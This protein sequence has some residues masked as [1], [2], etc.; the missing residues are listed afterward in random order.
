MESFEVNKL[1]G[2]LLATVFVVMS[3]AIVSDGIYSS[4]HP[5]KEGY[6]IVADEEAA[7][8]GQAGG[9]EAKP[10][11]IAPLIAAADPKAGEAVFKKCTACH[12]DTKGGPNKVGPNL[13]GVID[14]PI[15]SHAG[16]SYSAAMKE[17]SQGGKAVWDYD[18]LSGFLTSPK[19][20]VKNTAM[21]FG[22]LKKIEDRA[23]LLAYLRTMAD[24]PAP[25]PQ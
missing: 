19:G 10:Q 11:P 12:T 15:A 17:F 14:R 18:H 4:P 16:F 24:T 23:A 20:Y 7:A 25:L 8:S 21:G 1:I 3:I 9:E 22:G 6:E 2:A 13:W 5:E